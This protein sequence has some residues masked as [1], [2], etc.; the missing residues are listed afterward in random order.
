M[1]RRKVP[2]IEG[3]YY[4]IFNRSINKE[5]ILSTTK[6]CKRATAALNFYMY[7]NPPVRLSHFLA[8]GPD[9]RKEIIKNLEENYPRIVEIIA[10]C[11][12]PN[13]FHLL[14][15]QVQDRGISTFI[16]LFQNSYTRYFNTKY[17]RDGHLFKGQ[18]KAVRIEDD[19]Q[20]LHLTRY[21]HLNPYSSFVVRDLTQLENY[22]FSSLP[23]YLGNKQ[24]FCHKKIVID[25][26]RNIED[27][28]NFVF[29]QAE[30]QRRLDEIKHLTI[31]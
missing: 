5:P 15:K 31:E 12:M 23:E 19:E 14:L 30:Y 20:L 24:G 18:F 3:E 26:F 6:D 4:H 1:P 10:Y 9:K 27:F 7:K 17:Q 29:N 8:R 25:K 16:S 22:S 21:I 13:H 2:L 28:K 11:F